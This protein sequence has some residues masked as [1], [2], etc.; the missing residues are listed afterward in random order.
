MIAF[1]TSPEEEGRALQRAARRAGC[2]VR[3]LVIRQTSAG[4]RALGKAECK[5]GWAAARFL[6]ALAAEDS[7]TPGARDLALSIRRGAP[8]DRAFARAVH[9]YVK[10]RVRFVREAGEVF[11]GSAYTLETGGG[12]CDDHFR[13]VYALAMAGGLKARGAFLH[14]A[15]RNAQPTHALAQLGPGGEWAWAETTVDAWFGEHPID[16]A[17]RLGHVRQDITRGGVRIMTEDDL[18]PVPLNYNA[19]NASR[20]AEDVG[21]LQRLGFLSECNVVTDPSDP[22]FRRAVAGA[23]RALGGLVVD[24]LIGPNTRARIARELPR[25]EFG[26][27]YLGAVSPQAARIVE[28]RSIL[29]QALAVMRVDASAEGREALLSIAWGETRFGDPVLGW[30]DS[31]NWGGVT[32]NSA[33]GEPFVGWGF[34]AHPDKD[35]NG[36]PVV[37]KFQR[38]PTDLEGAKDKVRIALRSARAREA[39]RA[40]SVDDLA[41]AMFD[42][43]YYT[44][45]SGTREDRI[46]AYASMIRGGM[47]TLGKWPGLVGA[48]AGGVGVGLVFGLGALAAA[49]AA[50]A[51]WW[52]S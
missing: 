25:D 12:D 11:Q 37:Y 2:R 24:G 10:E 3:D 21:A 48:A 26:I 27:G 8:S 46:R 34:L 30:E 41:A 4:P 7:R 52:Q 51:A 23:Q 40:G 38:Y 22:E 49:G 29:S 19:K 31:H 44:G 33:R 13:V 47:A 20:L 1:Y 35:K 16:A 39:A 45:T 42:A 43:G 5:D 14:D 15:G 50:A 6:V 36:N 18:S 9:A 32:F 28:A 17:V